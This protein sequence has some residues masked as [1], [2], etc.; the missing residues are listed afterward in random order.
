MPCISY[1]IYQSAIRSKCV[2]QYGLVPSHSA[3]LWP[4]AR[5]WFS[6]PESIADTGSLEGGCLIVVGAGTSVRT[7]ILV[8]V[9]SAQECETLTNTA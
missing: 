8:R 7:Q 2:V 4:N 9:W 1:P 5:M 3:S 6:R